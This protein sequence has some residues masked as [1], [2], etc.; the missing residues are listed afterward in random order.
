MNLTKEIQERSLEAGRSTLKEFDRETAAAYQVNCDLLMKILR[1]NADTEYGR[2]Y[3]FASISSVEEYQKRVPVIV[4]DDIAEQIERMAG[5]EKNVL[6]AYSFTHLNNTSGTIGAMKLVPMTKEQTDVFFKY[7]YLLNVGVKDKYLDRAWVE[8]RAFATSEGFHTT[9]PSGITVGSASSVM[10]ECIHGGIEAYDSQTRALFTSP[11]E[12]S[13]PSKGDD[14]K[15]IHSRFALMDQEMTGIITGFFSQVVLYMSYITDNY[16]MLIDDIEKG[17]IS[18]SVELL[19]ETRKSL[20]RK[21][22]PMPERA[23]QLRSIFS[24]GSDFQWGPKV[25]PKLLYIRGV[26]A[27]GFSVYDR[28]IKERYTGNGISCLYSGLS[29]SEVLTSV[30]VKPDSPSS[31]LIPSSAFFEFIPVDA[32]DD[33]SQ[34]VT[35]DKVEVGKIYEVVAT[36]L[37]GFYRYRTRDAV[38]ITGFYNQTPMLEF[39]YRTNR[40]INLVGEKVTEKDLQWVVENTCDELGLSLADFSVYA[41]QQAVP[42]QYIFLIELF[43]RPAGLDKERFAEVLQKYMAKASYIYGYEVGIGSIAPLKLL[44]LQPETSFLYRDMMVMRGA[45]ASQLKPVR[46]IMNERQR[47]F[48]FRLVEDEE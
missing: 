18:E 37:C 40:N 6:T 1:D 2:K 30:C 28:I 41:D 19:P 27:D 22:S 17:T 12:A 15:Y 39:M 46:I 43:R 26:G 16:E 13:L 44:F 25:W 45:S 47:R 32:G 48:F 11:V 42:G 38:K 10:A 9:L 33:F 7:D 21:I 8:G 4:Y 29:A 23:A 24:N 35:L 14:T 20:M 3:G 34:I 36:N 5:G 31:A